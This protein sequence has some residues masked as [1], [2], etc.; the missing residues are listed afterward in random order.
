VDVAALWENIEKVC[1]K[2]PYIKK[3][4]ISEAFLYMAVREG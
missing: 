4:R 3:P 1:R 2:P